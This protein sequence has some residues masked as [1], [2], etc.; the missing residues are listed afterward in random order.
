MN[1]RV[2]IG[3]FLWICVAIAWAS[4][5]KE[6]PFKGSRRCKA[7][8]ARK[9]TGNQYGKWKEGPHSKAYET[10][11]QEEAKK[12][13]AKVGIED[14]QQSDSCLKCHTTTYEVEAKWLRGLTLQ[15][16]V[17]CESCHGP[18]G[19]YWRTEIM[20]NPEEARAKGLRL[21]AD[22]DFCITCHNDGCPC[23][24][25]LDLA[26]GMKTIKHWGSLKRKPKE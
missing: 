22:E 6:Y 21:P 15:E 20:K 4:V 13:A 26:E 14:P 12:A 10:L 9:D 11:G 1:K 18:G 2:L 17:S 3:L 19:H 7:C 5:A 25:P 23:Y 16:G 24:Q 8:H